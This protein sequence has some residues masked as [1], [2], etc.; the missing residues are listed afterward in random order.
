MPEK[1]MVKAVPRMSPIGLRADSEAV[2]LSNPFVA[3]ASVDG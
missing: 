3:A 1:M 2:N